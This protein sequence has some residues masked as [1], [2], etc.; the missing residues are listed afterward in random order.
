MD[1][2]ATVVPPK[3]LRDHYQAQMSDVTA[4]LF[5]RMLNVVFD[6][7]AL[8]DHLIED[9]LKDGKR[10]VEKQSLAYALVGCNAD[11]EIDYI[12]SLNPTNANPTADFEAR[13]FDGKTVRLELC[14]LIAPSEKVYL[15]ILGE[16]ARRA[17]AIVDSN[18]D[19][20]IM[21]DTAMY[22]LRCYGEVSDAHDIDGAAAELVDFILTSVRHHAP[23]TRLWE[24]GEQWATLARIGAFVA[25]ETHEGRMHIVPDPL[26]S[27]GDMEGAIAALASTFM[28]KKAKFPS[29]SDGKPVWLVTYSDTQLF[30]PYGIIEQLRNTERFDPSPFARLLFGCFTAGVVFE[31]PDGKPREVFPLRV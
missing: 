28:K 10:F 29:Y 7:V 13:M 21:R 6:E 20:E 3:T 19:P 18:R 31:A 25:R 16:I 30:L 12:G 24:A 9:G 14:R 23:S 27:R 15:N 26:R 1:I 5:E 22:T 8:G 2:D 17:Q 11:L 4:L